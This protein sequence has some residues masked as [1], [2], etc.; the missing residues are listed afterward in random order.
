MGE[1]HKIPVRKE[2][3]W[4]FTQRNVSLWDILEFFPRDAIGPRGP[5]D[6]PR[7]YEV[8]PV[9]VE[10]DLGWSFETDIQYGTWMFRPTSPRKPGMMRWCRER[11][12]EEGDALVFEK[13]GERRYRL[14]LEKGGRGRLR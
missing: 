14:A 9:I 6:E 2:D 1:I 7:P 13:L 5:R 11:G 8:R 12:L 4:T 3:V 10:T